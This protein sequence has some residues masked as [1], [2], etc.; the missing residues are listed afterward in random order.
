MS[1]DPAKVSFTER[2][3]ED[4]PDLPGVYALWDG[5]E[6]IYYGKADGD[7]VT[8]RSCLMSHW[9]GDKGPCTK[10]ATRYEIVE[11]EADIDTR[12]K[13]ALDHFEWVHKRRPRCNEAVSQQNRS[14]STR[15]ASEANL[16]Y[17]A[18]TSG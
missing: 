9:R 12:L 3:I 10:T 18:G 17:L 2:G 5:T 14:S 15:K 8:I 11:G 1:D 7:G 13:D 16:D 6:V 4:A